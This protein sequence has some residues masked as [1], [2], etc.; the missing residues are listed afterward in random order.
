M[1]G[2]SAKL[3]DTHGEMSEKQKRE[4]ERNRHLVIDLQR[5]L[6]DTRSQ[7]AKLSEIVDKQNKQLDTLRIETG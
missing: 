3:S 2:A 7:L 1:A 4:L 5:D 6:S